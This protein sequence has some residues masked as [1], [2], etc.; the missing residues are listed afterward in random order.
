M[1]IY[2]TKI[3][4]CTECKTEIGEVD[5]DSLIIRPLCGKCA[6]PLPEGE[7]ILYTVNATQQANSKKKEILVKAWALTL[8]QSL[9][10]IIIADGNN[11]H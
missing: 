7:K 9:V 3:I 5:Y 10:T 1:N 2:D 4:S 11:T 6:N 8:I